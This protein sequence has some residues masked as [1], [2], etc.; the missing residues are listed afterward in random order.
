MN[1]FFLSWNIDYCVRHHC[2]KHV[3]KMIIEYAQQLST[4]HRVLDGKKKIVIQNNRRLARY[5]VDNEKKND[6]L[7]KASHIN[8]PCN[9]WVRASKPNYEFLYKLFSALC[10]EYTYRYGKI[11][12]TDTK[13]RELLKDPPVN[14]ENVGLLKPPLA[15]PEEYKE[16]SVIKS[17]RKFYIGD[18]KKFAKYT[19][20]RT[21]LWLLLKTENFRQPDSHR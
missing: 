1:I 12:M 21:P 14:I 10:D 6:V 15:M 13:L 18:K 4:S 2:D 5:I 3:V 16:R 7:Y 9:I 17:Y 19:K 8:H 20:R 11:H